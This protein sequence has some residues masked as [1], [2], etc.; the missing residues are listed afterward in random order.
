MGKG[1]LRRA[2]P[3]ALIRYNTAYQFPKPTLQQDEPN[4]VEAEKLEA[5]PQLSQPPVQPPADPQQPL[6]I[7][8]DA[9]IN[10]EISNRFISA[11]L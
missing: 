2:H 3:C 6:S 8:T 11:S 5:S 7:A 10:R 1:A 9:K 4:E